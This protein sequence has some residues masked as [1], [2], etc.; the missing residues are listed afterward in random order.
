M[1]MEMLIAATAFLT[2]H[3]RTNI[4]LVSFH[5]INKNNVAKHAENEK[6]KMPRIIIMLM[7]TIKKII[8]LFAA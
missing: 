4:G 1:R 7:I 3:A 8:S 5:G 6:L 2:G